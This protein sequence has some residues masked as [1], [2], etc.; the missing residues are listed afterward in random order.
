MPQELESKSESQFWGKSAEQVLSELGSSENGLPENEAKT[1]LASFG[2]NEFEKKKFSALALFAR[3][4]RNP[5]LAILI[6][7]GV[8]SAFF[9]QVTTAVIVISIILL[10]ALLGFYDEYKSE[11]AVEHLRKKVSLKTVVLRGGVEEE[12]PV[13]DVV[14][15][16]VV[17]LSVG[18]IVPADLRLIKSKELQLNE[19]AITGESLPVE[20]HA[21]LIKARTAVVQDLRNCAFMGTIVASGSGVGVV[22]ATW[23]KHAVRIDFRTTRES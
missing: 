5:L 17:L 9:G 2:P 19:A 14:P 11:K 18:N 20:K 16:D 15:G 7:A 12:I 1:R 6:V 3:Q 23:E 21:G 22:T 8:V 13:R 4:F 10:S